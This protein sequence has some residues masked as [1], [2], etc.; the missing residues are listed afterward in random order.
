[1]TPVSAPER[2]TAEE[3]EALVGS[4][5]FGDALQRF[6][7]DESVRHASAQVELALAM[8]AATVPEWWTSVPRLPPA[9][10]P[11]RTHDASVAR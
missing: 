7:S 2:A 5:R 4:G 6:T 8:A 3:I 11:D 9:L 10:I 1:M